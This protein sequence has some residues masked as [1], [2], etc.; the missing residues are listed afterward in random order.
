[1]IEGMLGSQIYP[2]RHRAFNFGRQASAD[3]AA[4]KANIDFELAHVSLFSH[5]LLATETSEQ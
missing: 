5:G 2:F 1:M 3:S 4:T